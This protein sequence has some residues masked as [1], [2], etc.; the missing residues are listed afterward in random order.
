[1]RKHLQLSELASNYACDKGHHGPSHKWSGNNYVDIYQAYFAGT[2]HNVKAVM[3]IGL[4][5]RGSE[6][7]AK[8]AHGQNQGGASIKM[9]RDFFPSA[10]IVGLDINDAS[11][12]NGDRIITHQVDQGRRDQLSAIRDAY[13]DTAFDLIV[14]DGSHRS[15]HQQTTLEELFPLL[16]PGGL[17]VIEDLNDQG[18]GSARGGPHASKNTVNTRDW[19][20]RYVENGSLLPNHAFNSTDFLSQCSEINFHAPAPFLRGRD[21]IYETIRVLLGRSSRGLLRREFNS[22]SHRIVALRKANHSR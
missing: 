10:K 9:W 5:V 7:E 12:L 22:K 17:Y 3:E 6:F 4:G 8:V 13:A 11:F 18:L 21:I 20:Y 16:K 19:F 15:D 1:M 2:R 14:D